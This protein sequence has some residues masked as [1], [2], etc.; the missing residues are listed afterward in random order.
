MKKGRVFKSKK[1]LIAYLRSQGDKVY[2]DAPDEFLFEEA[3]VQGWVE[4]DENGNYVDVEE[5]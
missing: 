3:F 4:I 2:N 5:V 1:E